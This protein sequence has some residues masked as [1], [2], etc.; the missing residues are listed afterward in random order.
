VVGVPRATSCGTPATGTIACVPTVPLPPA[1]VPGD[2][3]AVVAL[4][5]PV[6][7]DRLDG[8]LSVL[9]GWGLDVVEAPGLRA[10]HPDLPYLAG[11]DDERAAAFVGAW[12]DPEVR[13]VLVGRGGYGVPRIL[14]LLDWDALVAAGPRTLVGFSDVTPLLHAVVHHL[15]YAAVHGPA[16]TGI[17]DGADRSRESVR[18][19]LLG[20]A[21]ER[22]VAT[23][24]DVL[25]AGA[26]EGPLVGGNLAL[27]A[28]CPDD[29]LPARG[30]VVL[31]ED[32]DESPHRLDR[33]LTT[34]LRTGWLDDAA[35]VVLGGFT[36]CGDAAVARALLLDRLG[37]LGVPVVGGAPVGHDEPNVAV[38]LGALARIDGTT[39]RVEVVRG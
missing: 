34:L 24:L 7:E 17:G 21:G 38:P 5:S 10:R 29:L 26:A 32:V 25:V 13:A 1:L 14:D 4:S 33:T 12:T 31:L 30:A 16:V 11:S 36:R 35:G 18:D 8:G 15:G 23:G 2:R 39:L 3:V 27:L 28:A 19:L 37:D 9:R 6:P 20:P 22:V